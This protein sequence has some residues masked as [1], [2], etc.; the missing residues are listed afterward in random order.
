MVADPRLARGTAIQPLRD[1][2]ILWVFD[3]E[4]IRALLIDASGGL[5]PVAPAD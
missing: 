5:T 1:A 2:A 4:A 3:R